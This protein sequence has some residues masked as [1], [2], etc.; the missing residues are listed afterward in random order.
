MRSVSIIGLGRVGGAF[1]IALSRRG[2]KIDRLVFRTER[3]L[4]KLTEH[5]PT[6]PNISTLDSVRRF[7]SDVVFITTADPEIEDVAASISDKL[8]ADSVVLH[9][10]GSLPSTV[11]RSVSEHGPA[12]GSL[13]PLVAVSDPILG[14]DAFSQAYFCLEG[15]PKALA[16]ADEVVQVL[17]GRSFSI[18]TE[19]K[20]LYH[21]GAVMAAGHFVSLVDSSVGVFEKCGVERSQALSALLPLVES[22]L[23]NLRLQ[24]A[25]AALTGPFARADRG[26]IER[27][28]DALDRSGMDDEKR[29][30]IELG[31]QALKIAERGGVPKEKVVE[32]REILM[33]AKALPK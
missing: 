11:L 13:H 6:P 33:M 24:D 8:D 16:I 23:R 12:I 19:F 31:L 10:S 26:T 2:Y 20:S 21:A 27:H 17:N 1:A 4:S 32:I 29:V 15:E 14:A 25:S 18:D 30:Y 9:T 7:S 5:L 28:L 3:D 22:A